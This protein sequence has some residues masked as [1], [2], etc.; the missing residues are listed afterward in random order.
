MFTNVIYKGGIKMKA[1]GQNYHAEE[2]PNPY[3]E[4]VDATMMTILT[5]DEMSIQKT[6]KGIQR[7]WHNNGNNVKS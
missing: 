2:K 7:C 4:R 3:I 1:K 5:T 6:F